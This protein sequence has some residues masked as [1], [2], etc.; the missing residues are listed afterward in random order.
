MGA[1]F[2]LISFLIALS[3]NA[4]SNPRAHTIKSTGRAIDER[5]QL[6]YLEESESRFENGDLKTITTRYR[7][8]SGKLH[9]TIDFDF[10]KSL[11]LPDSKYHDIPRGIQ[12]RLIFHPETSQLE[13]SRTQNGVETKRKTV[14]SCGDITSG[15]GVVFFVR[16]K[17][18]QLLNDERFRFRIL[19][20]A[21]FEDY[22]FRLYRLPNPGGSPEHLH[23]RIDIGFWLY[24]LFAPDV[25]FVYD[26]Q[27]KRPIEYKGPSGI[28]NAK[29]ERPIVTVRFEYDSELPAS[30]S[31]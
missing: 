14:G 3:A 5:G 31:N 17:L 7:D 18:E 20:P 15:A 28:A 22:G 9:S 6:A 16:D 13:M 11:Y 12:D 19:V 1:S 23:L 2:T 24:R 10:S 21:K 29:G 8:T 26:L 4:L 27:K 25:T 30:P